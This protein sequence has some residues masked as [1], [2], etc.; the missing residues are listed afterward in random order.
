MENKLYELN[1]QASFIRSQQSNPNKFSWPADFKQLIISLVK[2]EKVNYRDISKAT[3]IAE[4]TLY[5]WIQNKP[6]VKNTFKPVNV[7]KDIHQN[8][9]LSWQSGLTIKGLSFSQIE[10]LLKQ[11]LL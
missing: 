9:T 10:E 4:S 6:K 1:K 2:V 11:G 3:G 5:G 8:L 7:K